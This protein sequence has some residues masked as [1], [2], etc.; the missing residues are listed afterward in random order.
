MGFQSRSNNSLIYKYSSYLLLLLLFVVMQIG[1]STLKLESA[2]R[3]HDIVIDG[4]SG[5]WLGAKYYFE[6]I[7]VSVGLI[8]DDHHLYVSL[9]T[10]NRMILAQIMRKGLTLWLDPKGGKD[11]TFGIKF[12][13]G[14]QGEEGM[15]QESM[16]GLDRE[17]VMQ[18]F[19]ESLTEL[20][21]IGLKDEVVE[22]LSVDDAK[23]IDVKLRAEG[24]LLIYEIKVPLSSSEEH[25]YAV[26]AKV[27][28]TIGFG[29]ESPKLEMGRPA[30]MRG[31]G[32]PGGGRGGGPPG[33]IGGGPP[34]GMGGMPGGGKGFQMPEKLKIWAA[35]KLASPN[36]EPIK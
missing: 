29:F 22:K 21:I 24:G 35:A 11:K 3:N 23:G 31:G 4:K 26:G 28:D 36:D 25:P 2:W 14:S 8:N 17:V 16:E 33:G 6:D 34:A 9:M 30:G 15:S 10:E 7:S 13:L 18:R 32:M 20:E 1:C 19:E 5:D 12:P 27:G